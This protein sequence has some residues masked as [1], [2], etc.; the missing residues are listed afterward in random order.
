MRERPKRRASCP[1]HNDG[2]GLS[3]ALRAR[4]SGTVARRLLPLA[5]LVAFSLHA[6]AVAATVRFKASASVAGEIVTL[7]DV[8]D[9]SHSDTARLDRLKRM[10]LVPT[11]PP[12][13]TIHLPFSQIRSRLE[14][15]GINLAE[16]DFSGRSVVAV[17]R[18]VTPSTAAVTGDA[19]D[20][21]ADD[22]RQLI[23]AAASRYLA[24]K[25]PELGNIVVTPELHA[26]QSPLFREVVDETLR[27]DGGRAPWTGLQQ[28][29][30]HFN[31]R[32]GRD[33]AVLVKATV[34]P[35]PWVLTAAVPLATGQLVHAADLERRQMAAPKDAFRDAR[36]V[37]GTQAARA[38]RAGEPMGPDEIVSVPLI[39][40]GDTVT[41]YSRRPGIVVGRRMRARGDGASGD[42]VLLTSF[43]GR[44][45]LSA[46]VVGVREAEVRSQRSEV[47][48]Q[49]S[50]VR[51][52]Q[53]QR[54][55][56]AP[57]ASP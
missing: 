33:H 45:R 38:I 7:S 13:Q 57:L 32:S 16:L 53:S 27:L 43:D 49:R 15:H 12:G 36:Q 10:E 46:R 28:F 8:A 37:V 24:S 6:P 4:S 19:S 55:F 29:T 20:A 42:D 34:E 1:E 21:A 44:E 35:L 9:V 2:R 47:R 18:S 48:D 5:F 50:E 11:P 56:A 26:A 25:A 22:V 39:R 23:I 17:R 52:R 51:G 14:A 31:D 41:V 30:V 54:E 40:S 3:L